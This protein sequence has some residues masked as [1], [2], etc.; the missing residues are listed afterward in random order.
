MLF[1]ED[2]MQVAG[3]GEARAVGHLFERHVR[4][5]FQERPGPGEP[6]LAD[7]GFGG[8]ADSLLKQ[9]PILHNP[10][11]GPVGE[12]GDGERQMAFVED[13]LNAAPDAAGTN[14]RRPLS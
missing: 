7:V 4:I 6:G 9:F 1:T 2:L 11:A 13:D 14:P 3:I 5:G 12:V 8:L 10:E